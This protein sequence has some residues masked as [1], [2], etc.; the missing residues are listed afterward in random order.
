MPSSHKFAQ[1]GID[2]PKGFCYTTA[3]SQTSQK[4]DWKMSSIW[5][6][7]DAKSKF[8]AVVDRACEIEPQIVTRRG[9]PVVVMISYSEYRALSS[10]SRSPI[11]V[12]LGGP[13]VDGGL[14][15]TR[16]KSPARRVVFA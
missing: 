4:G 3:T 7:Q 13:K 15:I 5:A 8:S 10:P 2:R 9:K 1:I 6:L 16:D 12:L 14:P 11:D